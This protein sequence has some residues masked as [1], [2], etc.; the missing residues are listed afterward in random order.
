MKLADDDK[1]YFHGYVTRGQRRRAARP[2]H[3]YTIALR[4]WLWFLTRDRRTAASSR[5]RASRTSSPRCCKDYR[6]AD[7][8]LEAVGSYPKLD[9]CVQYNETDFDFVS[10]LIEEVGIYYFFE[11]EDEQAHDGADRRDDQAQAT[12]RPSDAIKWAHR[13]D[14]PSRRSRTGTCSRRCAPPRR[15]VPTTTISARTTEIEG[16]ERG[17]GARPRCSARWSGSSIRPGSCRT[18]SSRTTRPA[19]TRGQAACEGAYGGAA[20]A[21]TRRPPARP[22]CATSASA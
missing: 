16:T 19:T 9:Y 22:T 14:S 21:R 20:R 17:Q 4:P 18:A 2:I 11:H 15:C 8:K 6:S 7:C 13:D 12:A 10:R 3:A 1:R 5:R